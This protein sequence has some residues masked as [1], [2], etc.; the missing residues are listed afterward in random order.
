MGV[1]GSREP[2]AGSFTRSRALVSC[3]EK[4]GPGQGHRV[5]GCSAPSPA[6]S[7]RWYRPLLVVSQPGI[8]SDPAPDS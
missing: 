3:P 4:I 7:L 2:G 8:R 5:N 6:C 1:D